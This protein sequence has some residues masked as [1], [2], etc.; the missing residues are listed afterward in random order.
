MPCPFLGM[1]CPFL[2]TL[3]PFLGML[4][5]FLGMPCEGED[6]IHE[7]SR[8]LHAL[9]GCS[10]HPAGEGTSALGALG[11]ARR[12]AMHTSGC[13]E[14]HRSQRQVGHIRDLDCVKSRGG[15]VLI[16]TR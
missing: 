7:E 8:G 11:S 16:W 1:P 2:G 6:G 15:L 4:H 13:P 14:S 9:H 12:R 5:A 3:W 10:A